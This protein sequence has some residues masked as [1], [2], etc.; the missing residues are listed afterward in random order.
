MEWI[1]SDYES[2]TIIIIDMCH[3]GILC[4]SNEQVGESEGEW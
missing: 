1:R 3:E 4:G 2:P